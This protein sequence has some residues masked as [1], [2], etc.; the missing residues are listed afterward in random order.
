MHNEKYLKLHNEKYLKLHNELYMADDLTHAENMSEYLPRLIDQELKD[1]LDAVGAVLIVGPK[2]CGKSTTGRQCAKSVLNLQDEDNLANYR[3]IAGQKISLLLQGDHPR[4]IDEWQEIP[5]LWDAVRS[6]V[7]RLNEAGL[8]ILTGSTT[9]DNTAIKHSGAGRI[10]RLKMRTM[11]LYEQGVSSGE[12]SMRELFNKT[13][14]ITG[15]SKL[16]YGELAALVVRGGWP[17]AVGKSKEQ[18]RRQIAGYCTAITET[19]ISTVDGRQRDSTKAALILRSLARRVSAPANNSGVGEDVAKHTN[20][21]IHRNTVMDYISALEKIYVLEDLPAWCPRLR[22]KTAIRTTAV[23][24][25]SD[26]AIA[27]YFL[28]AAAEDL[29]FDPRTFGLLFE[30]MA[31]RDLRIYAQALEGKVYHYRDSDGLEADAVVHLSD[32]RWGAFKIELGAGAIDTAAENLKKLQKKV[33][34][35]CERPPSFLAVITGTEYAYQRKDG[36]YVLPL[37]C[38]K[39]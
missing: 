13:P 15:R 33:D 28:D 12:V 21:S 14:E 7:D 9:V 1:Y 39:D 25:F 20:V 35:D 11:S 22:S 4:L 6:E 5:R 8:F 19:D 24:H 34:M 32:G 27:A 18:V 23:R 31:V 3:E 16:D 29:Q 38:L 2:W 10:A 30:S 26:P 37:G 17:A 36:V